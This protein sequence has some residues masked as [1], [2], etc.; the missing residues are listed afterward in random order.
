MKDRDLTIRSRALGIGLRRVMESAG[1]NGSQVADELGW[2]QGRVSR[3]LAG[4]RGGSGV[5]VSAF[6]AVCG[7][8]GEERERLLA[9]AEEHTRPGWWVQHG[10]VVPKRVQT[11][12]D[13][14]NRATTICELQTVLVPPLLQTPEYAR[15]VLAGSAKVPSG[16]IE[17]RVAARL[18]RQELLNR[19]WAPYCTFFLYEEALRLPVGGPVVMAEQLHHLL[20]LSVR[21]NVAIRVVPT[22]AGVHA[23]AAGPF[24]VLV[25]RGFKS[26]VYLEN[27]TSSLF[28]ETPVE[29][30]A[31]HGI[32]VALD[33]M[34]LDEGESREMI[35]GVALG[36]SQENV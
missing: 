12:A 7:V 36:F 30:E 20:R 14:E 17:E 5:D 29:I 4:K 25:I 34:A 32:L 35:G 11:L 33:G 1:Y 31:Y 8:K 13:L 24:T 18:E 6:L 10:L 22:S 23:G 15:A 21:P 3:L 16:E 28:L 19:P 27:E 9:L 2:S 26:V